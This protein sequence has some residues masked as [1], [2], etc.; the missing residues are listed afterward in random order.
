MGLSTTLVVSRRYGFVHIDY[1][2]ADFRY[3]L[4]RKSAPS[5]PLGIGLNVNDPERPTTVG[6]SPDRIVSKTFL[7][8]SQFSGAG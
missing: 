4:S 1:R 7:F 5:E 6:I 8:K 2:S 3:S